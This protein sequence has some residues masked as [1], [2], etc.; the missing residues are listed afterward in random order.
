[1]LNGFL[2]FLHFSTASVLFSGALTANSTINVV[3]VTVDGEDSNMRFNV[4]I[5]TA[6]FCTITT[7]FHILY[8]SKVI[9]SLTWRW[10]E[11][12]ISAPLMAV[13]IAAMC[14]ITDFFLLISIFGLMFCTMPYGHFAQ[15]NFEDNKSWI[16]SFLLGCI[17]YVIAWI[18]IFAAFIRNADGAPSFVYAIVVSMCIFFSM[19]AVVQFVIF[20]F[21]PNTNQTM[22][23]Y[24][25]TLH[26][27]SL[28]SKLTLSW[29]IYGGIVR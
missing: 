23:F 12:S 11:D 16:G 18:S 15:R 28:T 25:R 4:L 26:V 14:R 9:S 17:P 7:I 21:Y 5:A 10:V 3:V 27:L 8:E 13:I 20:S 1:M 24:D 6:V 19:F 29:L 22:I 2:S